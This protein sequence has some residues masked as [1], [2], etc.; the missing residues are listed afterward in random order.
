LLRE[1]ELPA[2]PASRIEETGTSSRSSCHRV[3]TVDTCA[4]T[5]SSSS[6]SPNG[7]LATHS[8]SV[9]PTPVLQSSSTKGSVRM[10]RSSQDH[11]D[12]PTLPCGIC[13][14]DLPGTSITSFRGCPHRLCQQCAPAYVQSKL[15]QHRYP[16]TCPTCM[17]NGETSHPGSRRHTTPCSIALTDLLHSS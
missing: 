8:R 12:G 5:P 4:V 2:R 1:Y 3:S 16:V 6:K 7:N 14:D 15:R 13:M 10:E 17:A 9:T 11:Q